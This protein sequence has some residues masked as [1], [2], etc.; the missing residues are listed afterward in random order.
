MNA[1]NYRGGS[2]VPGEVG[3]VYLFNAGPPTMMPWGRDG[4]L[5]TTFS[6]GETRVLF[7]N[8]PAPIFYSMRGHIRTVVPYELAGKKTAEVAVEYQGQ[9]S[10]P[11]TLPVVESAPALFTLDASGKGQ[12][13]ML[14]DTGCC[15]SVRIRRCAASPCP[16]T[17]LA[18]AVCLRDGSRETS[19]LQWA[20]PCRD[21]IHRQH[22]LA[23]GEF[24]SAP[25][26]TGG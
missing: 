20:E 22:R 23:A 10:A 13:A 25:E 8:K 4:N 17:P 24:S 21:S 3:V 6:M 14:N 16:Y 7:D 2:L 1:A 5:T 15:N 26:R 12:A 11:V 9:R 18:R 19:P